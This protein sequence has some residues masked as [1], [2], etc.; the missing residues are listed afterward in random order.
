MSQM[1]ST[2]ELL[3]FEPY[4]G[5][6]TKEN[7]NQTKRTQLGF[8]TTLEWRSLG[9]VG[10]SSTADHHSPCDWEFKRRPQ[11]FCDHGPQS[12]QAT[13]THDGPPSRLKPGWTA[14]FVWCM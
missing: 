10:L 2:R 6:P 12:R 5:R 4:V 8:G 3:Q 1:G 9:F 14:E 7:I 11:G 13:S